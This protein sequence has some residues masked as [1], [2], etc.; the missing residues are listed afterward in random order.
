MRVLFFHAILPVIIVHPMDKNIQLY[1]NCTSHTLTCNAIGASSYIWERQNG[2]IPN[3]S[4]GV[5]TNNL[6]L[7]NLQPEDAGDYRCVATSA[8]KNISSN[9]ATITISST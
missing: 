9:Y 3:D 7:V 4:T 1:S 8:G 6:T 5:N 2:N